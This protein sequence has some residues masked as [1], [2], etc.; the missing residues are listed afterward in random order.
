MRSVARRLR[1]GWTAPGLTSCPLPGGG[2]CFTLQQSRSGVYGLK[3][4]KK[5]SPSTR[6]NWTSLA[7]V[8]YD[9]EEDFMQ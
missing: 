8:C 9:L 2:E 5:Y 3:V 1:P 4:Q 7:G 6:R